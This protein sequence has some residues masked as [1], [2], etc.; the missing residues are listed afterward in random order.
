MNLKSLVFG[1]LLG[2]MPA[3]ACTEAKPEPACSYEA[4][5]ET[6]EERTA[7]LGDTPEVCQEIVPGHNNINEKRI[8]LTF[9]G[10]NYTPEELKFKAQDC[11]DCDGVNSGLMA[12]EPF[13]SNIDAFNFWY[14][15]ETRDVEDPQE[16]WDAR[17]FEADD[18]A[19]YLSYKCKFPRKVRIELANWKFRSNSYMSGLTSLKLHELDLE[20]LSAIQYRLQNLD[21]NNCRKVSKVCGYMDTNLDGVLD[22]DDLLILDNTSSIPIIGQQNM[23][24]FLEETDV[25]PDSDYCV[26][27]ME[28]DDEAL[29]QG[30]AE[31]FKDKVAE[32]NGMEFCSAMAEVQGK[33]LIT[34]SKAMCNLIGKNGSVMFADM[35]VSRGN[36]STL[37]HELGH[38]LW[39]LRDEYVE[40]DLVS[41][42]EAHLEGIMENPINCFAAPSVESCEE[43]AP[44]AG[45]VGEEG[46][47]CFQCCGYLRTVGD[48]KLFRSVNKGIMKGHRETYGKWNE[49]RACF[50]VY[51]ATQNVSGKCAEFIP[52]EWHDV[53]LIPNIPSPLA[54]PV[55]RYRGLFI[56]SDYDG[57]IGI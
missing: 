37:V 18:P 1:A 50:I 36:P 47:G 44:W 25:I 33:L 39:G 51:A 27:I 43:N 16:G 40:P 7:R 56:G 12:V 34:Y 2:L 15:N 57:M 5:E 22:R 28:G 41:N 24:T 6:P 54:E 35:R 11:V 29:K 42:P 49:K 31:S 8:N 38:G 20:N 23:C 3:T 53:P 26:S 9:V 48:M 10:V 46:T 14:V 52:I 32:I 21:K 55:F 4:I 13:K 17:G 45:M 19:K 30:Y